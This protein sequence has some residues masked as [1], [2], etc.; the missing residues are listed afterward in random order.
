VVF[1]LHAPESG[2][3]TV[4]RL[5]D[6]RGAVAVIVAF[7]MTALLV[8]AAFSVDV[9]NARQTQRNLQSSADSAAT[10]GVSELPGVAGSCSDGAKA[11]DPTWCAVDYGFDTLNF[12][13]TT[14]SLVSGVPS[15]SSCPPTSSTTSC[16]YQAGTNPLLTVVETNCAKA[17]CLKPADGSSPT[18]E[19]KVTACKTVAA[20]FAR[21]AKVNSFHPCESAT[22]AVLGSTGAPYALFSDSTSCDPPGPPGIDMSSSNN[23]VINGATRSN[24]SITMFNN[25]TFNGSTSYGGPNSCKLNTKNNNKFTPAAAADP[26]TIPW[27]HDYTPEL[28][29]I[30]PHMLSTNITLGGNGSGFNIS[31]NSGGGDKAYCTTGKI[32]VNGNNDFCTVAV[33]CTMVGKSI[34]ITG[35]GDVFEPSYAPSGEP[36]LLMFATA[37][38]PSSG[39]AV[40]FDFNNY[41]LNGAIFAPLGTINLSLNN[42]TATFLEAHNIVLNQNN[43]TVTGIGPSS[44][45]VASVQLVG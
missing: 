25:N 36:P 23:D 28:S 17:S 44:G 16:T 31:G 12:S 40:M 9:G 4:H 33:G 22:A 8:L 5:R 20:T 35:N 45:G 19:I 21:V 14:P 37:A 24:G 2:F 7:V 1:I 38:D 42:D 3:M 13:R 43:A 15:A 26:S 10:A 27:P 29:T 11:A 30:C 39:D 32:T 34:E 41:Q 6:E 18:W